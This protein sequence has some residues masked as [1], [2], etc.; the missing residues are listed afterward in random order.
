MTDLVRTIEMSNVS[1]DSIHIGRTLRRLSLRRS[2][3]TPT[4]Y[5]IEEEPY[6]IEEEPSDND[7]SAQVCNG[8]GTVTIVRT[9][10]VK[11]HCF[12][13]AADKSNGG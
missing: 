1:S 2:Q 12:C 8:I 5:D 7:F 6:D 9:Y 4:P 10:V 3:S 13:K 11:L